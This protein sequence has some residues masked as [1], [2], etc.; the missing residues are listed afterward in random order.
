L[1]Q[2]GVKECILQEDQKSVNHELAKLK[3][4]IERCGVIVTERKA[5]ELLGK[6]CRTLSSPT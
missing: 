6:N 4:L 1:I 2:L 5:G 3:T